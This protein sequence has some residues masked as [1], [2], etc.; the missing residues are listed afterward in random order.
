MYQESRNPMRNLGIS[1]V[2]N[3][4][5]TLLQNGEIVYHLENERLSNRK[6]DAFPFQCLTNL[7]TK[8][9]DNICIAGV[10]KLTPADCFIDDDPYSL[11]V[12]TKENK[13]DTKV[14]DLSL[15]HHELHAA[16]AFYNS[17]FDEAICIVK[18]GMGSDVPLTGDMFQSGTYG[19]ELSSTFAASYPANF[20]LIERHVAVPF[21][22][23]DRIGKTFISN[24]LGE[25]MAF[26]KTSMAFGFHEL[27]AGKVMGMASYGEELPISIYEDC[28]I[29]NELF[30]I[31]NDLHDT[32]INFIFGDF[33]SKADFAFTLQK[34]TQEHVAQHILYQIEQTG[35]KNVCLSGGF[36][37]NCVANYY[38]LSVLPSDVNLYI[39]PVSSDAGTSIGAAKLI[40]HGRT[41]DM[42]KRPLKNLYLGPVQDNFTRL[43]M[44][45]TRPTTPFEVAD[46]IA[47]GKIIAIY[48]GRSEAGPR[49]L[50]NRS[51]LFDPRNKEAKNII[52]RV[53]RREEFRPFAATV[54]EE[55][56]DGWFDMRGLSQSPYM[57]YAVN[58]MSDEIPGV[59]HVDN[60]CRVQTVN[61]DQNFHFYQL[62]NCFHEKTGV[63]ILFNTSFNLAG[64]CIVETPVDAIETMKRS[65]IDAIYFA[66]LGCLVSNN[67]NTTTTITT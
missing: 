14:H 27:D 64:E 3:S 31:G 22:A 45:S 34:Q 63:P 4:S 11:Y 29:D 38:Y 57:M 25:G 55:Y 6:Y 48:Q 54:M 36:F 59:T 20:N 43:Y 65:K 40:H 49:A 39:E 12:K 24:N 18:D 21:E 32:G 67:N 8:N 52:N 66:E 23:R 35:C 28:L 41:G 46:M 5:T 56:A 51:I 30:Y 10:G 15:S 13:Y 47:D 33:N 62:I 26:Q 37:L 16:H 50:G 44:E 58:V 60:T 53:K 17:G 19:R 1:R 7:D 9:L 61:A 42:T 2:H